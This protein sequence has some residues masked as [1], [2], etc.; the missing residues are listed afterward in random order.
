M[1]PLTLRDLAHLVR[2][3]RAG[4]DGASAELGEILVHRADELAVV[5]DVPLEAVERVMAH[6]RSIELLAAAVEDVPRARRHERA[7][8]RHEEAV[9]LAYRLHITQAAEEKRFLLD[10]GQLRELLELFPGTSLTFSGRGSV[11]VARLR[12]ILRAVGLFRRVEVAVTD[13]A[14]ELTYGALG[15]RGVIRLRLHPSSEPDEL[16]VRLPWPTPGPDP[17]LDGSLPKGPRR[18]ED[19]PGGAQTTPTAPRPPRTL[20]GRPGRPERRSACERP[21]GLDRNL[22]RGAP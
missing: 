10:I 18:P 3:W 7:R 21:S 1:A 14:L 20:H 9:S 16:V 5:L 19:A 2:L 22:S 4:V 11:R 8:V 6:P 15:L 12:A 17:A 13:D